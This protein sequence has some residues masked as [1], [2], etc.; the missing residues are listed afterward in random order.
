MGIFSWLFGREDKGAQAATSAP[1]ESVPA[2]PAYPAAADGKPGL[3]PTPS[4]AEN[5]RRWREAGQPRAWVEA[6][7]GQWN[8]ADWVAL[9]ESLKNSP[10]WPMQPEDVGRVLEETKRAGSERK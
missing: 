4:E 2:A 5:L 1:R 3:A 7:K 6:R 9:L 8:H 10:Y